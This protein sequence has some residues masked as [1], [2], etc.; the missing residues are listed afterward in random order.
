MITAHCGISDFVSRPK[1][2]QEGMSDRGTSWT[3]GNLRPP[4]ATALEFRVSNHAKGLGRV[5][6][7][8]N[9]CTMNVPIRALSQPNVFSP[10]SKPCFR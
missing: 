6:Y 3:Q 10:R 1:R 7:L 2:R 5:G 8:Y 9:K 4:G